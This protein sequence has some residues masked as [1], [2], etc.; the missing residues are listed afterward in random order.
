MGER[1]RGSLI[2]TVYAYASSLRTGTLDTYFSGGMS[3]EVLPERTFEG[4]VI[5]LDFSYQQF[6]VLGSYAQTLYKRSWQAAVQRRA[7]DDSTL[8]VFLWADEYQV[9]ADPDDQ[10]FCTIGRES[11]VISVFLTQ[12]ISNLYK[13]IGNRDTVIS[14]MGNMVNKIFHQNG[15]YATNE[16]AVRTIGKE[17][18]LGAREDLRTE[19]NVHMSTQDKDAILPSTFTKLRSGGDNH[20]YYVESIITGDIYG[21][22]RNHIECTFEQHFANEA[23]KKK[24]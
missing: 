10:E 11:R 14:M 22:G 7:V 19:G 24:S 20:D 5:I 3:E 6:G 18:I 15:D 17:R 23:R 9:L 1:L 21:S 13:A 4:K 2:E 16:F 12:N 8:P